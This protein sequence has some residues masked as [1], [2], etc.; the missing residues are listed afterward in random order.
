M[1]TS[2]HIFIGSALL[3]ACSVGESEAYTD[4]E[5]RVRAPKPAAAVK[6][7]GS[8][9]NIDASG[10]FVVDGQKFF[11]LGFYGVQW[12]QPFADRLKALV[13]IGDAGFNTMV[14][15]DIST[16]A[17]GDLLDEAERRKVKVLVGSASLD[18]LQYIG[19]TV[20]KYKA[21]PSVLGWSLFDDADNGAL[22]ISSLKERSDY[23]K[24]KDPDH[25][26]FSSL[27]GYYTG[28][29]NAKNDWISASDSS[30]LQMYPIGP[31]SDFSYD[32]GGDPLVESYRVTR[33]YVEASEQVRK[34]FVVSSQMYNWE[35]NGGV[36]SRYPTGKELRNMVYGQI[37]AGAK[38]IAS[39]EYTNDL[40]DNQKELWNEYVAVKNDVVN[41]LWSPILEGKL[42]RSDASTNGVVYSI[43]EYK[44]ECIVAIL[45]TSSSEAK[46]ARV[47]LPSTCARQ[48]SSLVAR[49]PST[50]Q[51]ENATLQGTIDRADVQVYKTAP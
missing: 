15:E 25:V 41:L 1:R 47:P 11:P 32:Y 45:N 30:G 29:R 27:T 9:S 6:A 20:D 2:T 16:D 39:F 33:D 44:N 12:R 38:G 10:T 4:A 48:S 7:V 42:T 34:P 14:A 5:S 13:T 19:A 17:F 23:V 31:P 43:W 18:D 22:S 51:L 46:E 24:A 50:M 35:G 37:M 28:R 21:K 49:L 26:T 40:F 8:K 3:I 36:G